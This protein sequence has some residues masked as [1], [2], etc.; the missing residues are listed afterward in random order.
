MADAAARSSGG[1][2]DPAIG[3]EAIVDQGYVIV[4]SPD[5]VT[6]KLRTVATKLNVGHLMLLLKFGNMNRQLTQHNTELF[7]KRV[8]P[9]IEHLFDDAWEDRWWPHALSAAVAVQ[10]RDLHG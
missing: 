1:A 9:Q 8:L 5:E 10:R 3:C 2:A 4:G 7:A 6:E